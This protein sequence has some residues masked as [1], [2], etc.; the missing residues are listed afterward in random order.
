M[1]LLSETVERVLAPQEYPIVRER[2]TCPVTPHGLVTKLNTVQEIE[3]L[4][5]RRDHKDLSIMV[6]E[7]DLAVPTGWGGHNLGPGTDLA[8]PEN[9]PAARLDTG[10]TLVL[11]LS[12]QHIEVAIM[13]KRSADIRG[14]LLVLA[15]PQQFP[16]LDI[17]RVDRA[18]LRCTGQGYSLAR[19]R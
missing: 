4:R 8:H 5:V 18:L 6:L 15:L 14:N 19:H 16:G 11:E 17:H 12:I 3:L 9:F 2:E 10:Q 13:V 7:I 1:L